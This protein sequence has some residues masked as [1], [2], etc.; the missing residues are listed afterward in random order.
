MNIFRLFHYTFLGAG[1]SL[2]RRV[3]HFY[4][5]YVSLE[6]FSL[7]IAYDLC[8]V[9][10]HWSQVRLD[11]IYMHDTYVLKFVLFIF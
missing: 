11:T 2:L 8:F 10:S 3:K 5:E 4:L 6:V 1:M 7:Y 9:E